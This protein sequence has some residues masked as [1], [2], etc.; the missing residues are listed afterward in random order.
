MYNEREM[1]YIYQPTWR[2]GSEPV[3][4]WINIDIN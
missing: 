2:G 4:L 3:V 1:A